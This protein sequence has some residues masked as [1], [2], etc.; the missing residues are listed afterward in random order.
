[1]SE[2]RPQDL[3]DR[4]DALVAEF[5]DE[6]ARGASPRKQ[7]Y[8]ERVPAEA[9]VGLERCLKRIESGLAAAPARAAV[10]APG[11]VLG[12]YRLVRELGRGGM[13]LVWLAHDSE[14]Q[15]PV[16]L[17]LLRPGLALEPTHVDRFR[18]EAL[19]IARL[20][21]AH[22]V[23]IHDVGS[24]GGLHYLAM[25]YVE[26]PSLARVLEALGPRE[27]RRYQADELA[28]AAGIPAL[29]ARG[30]TLEQA[31]AALLAPV[32]EALHAAHERGIVHRDVKPSNLL[33]R[34][35][36]SAVVA[37]FGLAKADGD[38][39]LS[40]TGDTLGT[41]YY[42]SPEQAYIAGVAVDHRTDVYSLGVC[43]YEALTGARPFEG[44]S[45]LEVFERI[46]ST[47]PPSLDSLEPRAS[48]DAAALV[49]RAMAREPEKRYESARALAADLR[50]LAEGLS[51]SAARAEGGA[52]RRAWANTRLYF[53]GVPFEYRS[54]R[55]LLGWPLVHV[56]SGVR[57]R[58][59]PRRVA[60]GWLAA[61]PEVA[62]GFLALGS[63]AYGAIACG[64][65]SCG[66]LFSWGG[67]S[68]GL[69]SAFGGLSAALFS[70]GGVSAGYVAIG[71]CSLGYGA[72]G[73]LAV[74][75]YG[76]GGLVYAEHA[77]S[78]TRHDLTKR[79]FWEI[80]L[81]WFGPEPGP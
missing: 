22:I 29:A 41:P 36:G 6:L 62:L 39:A 37:D 71:G 70:F 40:I 77:L 73:G 75:R 69:L 81:P 12:R 1:M 49:R 56:Y 33:L 32:A 31:L 43:V 42:M 13:A 35:D 50:T 79:E 4:L 72:I 21:H 44:A 30:G 60:R 54:A 20:K 24:A 28:R 58:G 5:S 46:R 55:T 65:L 26:G 19:A 51:T 18:R 15:R 68:L 45:V 52:L 38:P 64:G 59:R 63:R 61:S 17:K 78:E 11:L 80:L 76:M 9:R 74:G 10:L 27:K 67:I 14:L 66:L 25:E 8:L 3:D 16:A 48:R 53:S 23:Q 2:P 34:P 57:E 47:F 7:A